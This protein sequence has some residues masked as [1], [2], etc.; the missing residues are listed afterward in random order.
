VNHTITLT[1]PEAASLVGVSRTTAYE[2]V[3]AGHLPSVRLGR[4]II[5]PLGPLLE[6]LG[7]TIDDWLVLNRSEASGEQGSAAKDAVTSARSAA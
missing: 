6:R 7:M 3:R 1:V 2:L 4:R 5:V